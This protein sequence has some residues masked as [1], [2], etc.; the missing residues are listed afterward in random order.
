MQ[1]FNDVE[2]IEGK[3][4]ILVPPDSVNAKVPPR[5]PAFFNPRARLNRDFSVI[6]YSAFL[7][8][9]EGQKIF[10]DGLA[11]IGS[12]GLRVANEV[13]SIDK[14]IV[15]DLNPSALSLSLRSAQL[16]NLLNYEISENETCRFLSSHSRKGERAAIVDVDPFGSPSKYIDCAIRATMHGGLFSATATDLQVLHGLAN[17]ACKRRYYGIPIK[18]EY[19]NEIAIRLILGCINMVAARFDV[20]IVPLFVE[21]EMHYYRTY[22]RILN[23]PVQQEKMGYILHCNFCGNRTISE[24][25]NVCSL[26]NSK[27]LVAGPLWIGQLFSKEFVLSMLEQI[28]NCA[29]DKKCEKILQ[30]CTL[31]TEMPGTYFTLD[32]IAEKMKCAPLSLKKAI[33]KLQN[34]GFLASPTSLNFKG[35]RTSANIDEL[36]EIFAS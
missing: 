3:T 36:K 20:E 11:G 18:T 31:E 23:K 4:K 12:R 28:P 26:C 5:E 8:N 7:K 32:E 16:N 24:Q 29:V 27:V 15:N 1:T 22:V 10:L 9:F 34:R 6:A 2:I 14:V 25:S 19:G 17:D 35:L 33:T 21:N 13:K 30:R